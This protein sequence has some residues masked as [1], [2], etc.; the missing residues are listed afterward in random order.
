MGIETVIDE[1]IGRGRAEADEIRNGAGA[2][3]A[4]ILQEERL[5]GEKFIAERDRDAHVRADRV[6]VQDLARAELESKKIVLAAQKEILDEVY[7]MGLQ[8]LAALPD[9]D[10]IVRAL[11]TENA[12]DWRAGKVWA[13]PRDADTV[14]AVTGPNFAGTTECLGGV[15]IESADGTRRNDLRFEAL[16]EE[17]W[18][19]SVREVAEILWPPH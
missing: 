13:S 9:R 7:S 6:R 8:A 3:R 1:V 15:V 17:V 11:L 14:R 5:E 4:K 10:A 16:F 18:R 12:A 19:D 2:D